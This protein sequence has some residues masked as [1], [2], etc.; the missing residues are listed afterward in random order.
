[1]KTLSGFPI[2]MARVTPERHPAAILWGRDPCRFL[3]LR[4]P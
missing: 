2:E 4:G 1:L 3:Y